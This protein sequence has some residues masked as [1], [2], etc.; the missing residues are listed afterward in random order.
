MATYDNP[1]NWRILDAVAALARARDATPS[2][3]A[4]AW[5][6]AKPQVTSVIFGARSVAQVKANVAAAELRL[7]AEEVAGL[8]EASEFEVGYPYDFFR[9]VLGGRW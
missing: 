7:T 5:L 6:L 1:R 3:V 9:R 4:L 8:D 2:A